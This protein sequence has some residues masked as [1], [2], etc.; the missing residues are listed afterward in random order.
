[1]ISEPQ[2]L[3]IINTWGKDKT[4][5]QKNAFAAGLATGLYHC[6]NKPDWLES[7]IEQF[8]VMGKTT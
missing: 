3:H 6:Q 7:V 2:A 4:E 5:E 8:G 1:M